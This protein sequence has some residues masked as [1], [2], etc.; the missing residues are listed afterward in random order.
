MMYVFIF[1]FS[2]YEMHRDMVDDE[3]GMNND[4]TI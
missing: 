1:K 3:C 2:M 4:E